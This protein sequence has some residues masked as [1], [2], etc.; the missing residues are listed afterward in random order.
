MT[1][2]LIIQKLEKLVQTTCKKP[3]NIYGY[4]AWTHHI[5]KVVYFSKIL[6]KKTN[7]DLEIVEISALLHDYASVLNRKYYSQHEIIGARL[8]QSILEKYNYPPDKI[9]IV[10]KCILNHRGSKLKEKLSIEEKCIA[11][12][13]AMAHFTSIASLFYLCFNTHKLNIEESEKW[14]LA[15]L[16]RS[17]KKISPIGRKIVKPYFLAAKKILNYDR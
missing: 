8:A 4:G 15:K 7:A 1:N 16:Q 17:Y 14:I 11:D 5:K 9:K 13:D 3:S 6:A 10:K 12:A 2:K